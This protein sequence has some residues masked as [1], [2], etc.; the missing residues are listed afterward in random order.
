VADGAST[1][2]AGGGDGT[3]R[4]V[5]VVALNAG[6]AFG[7]LPLGTLNHFARDAGIPGDLEAALHTLATGRTIAV[8]VGEVNG[9]PFLNNS[10]IGL[11]PRLVWEREQQQR[12]GHR[13][14]TALAVASFHV[15][16]QYRRLSVTIEDHGVS[17]NIRTPFVFIGNNVYVVEGGRIDRRDRLDAGV[18]QLCVAPG[19]DRAG[20]LRLVLAAVAGRATSVERFETALTAELT[21]RSRHSR[22]GVALDGEMITLRPPLRYRIHPRALRLVVPL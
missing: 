1:L 15:W 13:K 7:V 2:V 19:I 20:M 17:R 4:S 10:S 18:L 21:I 22:L 14:W 12:L 9:E 8:D 11:Y 6:V 5:A 3:A 16:Q